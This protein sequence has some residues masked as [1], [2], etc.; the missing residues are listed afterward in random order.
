VAEIITG[1][2]KVKSDKRAGI[3]ETVKRAVESAT[4]EERANMLKALKKRKLIREMERH[5]KRV[6]RKGGYA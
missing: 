5:K 1:K 3:R 6:G 4:P 2:P